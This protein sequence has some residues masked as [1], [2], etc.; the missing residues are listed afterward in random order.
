MIDFV[1]ARLDDDQHAAEKRLCI[2]CGNR[3]APLRNF[4][5]T[6]GYTHDSWDPDRE[7]YTGWE[8]RRCPGRLT[9]AEPVQRP[10]RV[11]ADIA[12]KRLVVERHLTGHARSYGPRCTTPGHTLDAQCERAGCAYDEITWCDLCPHGE[13]CELQSLAGL[14]PEHADFQPGWRLP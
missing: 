13:P 11:L 2:H 6:V 14:W 1:R 9:G 7:T 12:F 5:G 4:F 3:T 10:E 8:G